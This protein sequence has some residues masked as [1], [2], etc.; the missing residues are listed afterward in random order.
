MCVCVCVEVGTFEKGVIYYTTHN[1]YNN[2][3]TKGYILLL[4]P[5]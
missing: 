4:E 5:I 1:M 3:K 2:S